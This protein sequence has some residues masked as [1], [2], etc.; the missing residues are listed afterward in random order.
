MPLGSQ[1]VIAKDF[2]FGREQ[3]KTGLPSVESQLAMDTGLLDHHGLLHAHDIVEI[4]KRERAA[5]SCE[6]VGEID[7]MA[8]EAKNR[9]PP[10]YMKYTAGFENQMQ[11]KAALKWWW[12][13]SPE[14]PQYGYRDMLLNL[15]IGGVYCEVQIGLAPLVAVRRKMHK[16]Y[17]IVRSTGADPL[18]SMAKPLDHA[19][20]PM[21]TTSE[22]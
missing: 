1:V 16:F 21:R 7:V 3:R 11:A 4:V 12:L 13:F 15:K 5:R 14:N 20:A 10:H 9:P 2:E 6:T 8:E 18:I 19:S 17:G 22:D